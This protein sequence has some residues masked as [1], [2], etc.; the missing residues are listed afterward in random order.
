MVLCKF[1]CMW[2]PWKFG[3]FSWPR[4][5]PCPLQRCLQLPSRRPAQSPPYLSFSA[6]VDFSVGFPSWNCSFSPSTDSM[7][8]LHAPDSEERQRGRPQWKAGHAAGVT[9]CKGG[10]RLHLLLSEADRT[11][12]PGS[13]LRF[14]PSI[15]Q[16]PKYTAFGHSSFESWAKRSSKAEKVTRQG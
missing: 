12:A 16:P 5:A 11:P 4:V 14:P 3:P 10:G 6:N 8:S 1:V 9:A 7:M 13:P 2:L 15:A